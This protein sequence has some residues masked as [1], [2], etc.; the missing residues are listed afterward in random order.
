MVSDKFPDSGDSESESEAMEVNHTGSAPTGKFENHV[1]LTSDGGSDTEGPEYQEVY[2]GMTDNGNNNKKPA[3]I[4]EQNE[5]TRLLVVREVKR[6]GKS[7]WSENK[8]VR[9]V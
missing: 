9:V 3:V 5:R 2:V 8:A 6:P 4:N 7:E 1:D